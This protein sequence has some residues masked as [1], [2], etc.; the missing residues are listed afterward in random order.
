MASSISNAEEDQ[1]IMPFGE[2]N[3]LL[4][5][6]LPGHRVIHMSSNLARVVSLVA[7]T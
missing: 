5:P 1:S 7:S 4:V 3:G 2:P 6:H